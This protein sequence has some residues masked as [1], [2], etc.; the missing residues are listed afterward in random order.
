VV[1]EAGINRVTEKTR[2]YLLI[3]QKGYHY[4]QTMVREEFD[5]MQSG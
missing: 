5:W 4:A 3:A 2:N 1:L